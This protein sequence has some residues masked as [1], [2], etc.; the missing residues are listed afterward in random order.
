M[1]LSSVLRIIYIDSNSM[2]CLPRHPARIETLPLRIEGHETSPNEWLEWANR[3]V[4]I[5]ITRFE[6]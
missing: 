3:G 6:N 2:P 5:I 4:R 1:V